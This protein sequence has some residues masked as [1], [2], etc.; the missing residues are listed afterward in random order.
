MI[1]VLVLLALLGVS[2]LAMAT[3]GQEVPVGAI[4]AL[5]AV[6]VVFFGAGVHVAAVLGLLGI[7]VGLVFSDR[8]WWDFAGQTLWGPSSNFVLVA[9]PLFL[10]MGEILLR[11]GLSDRLYRALNLWLNRLPGGLLHTNIASCAVFSAIS[12]SSV[13]T[14]ATMGSVA[15]PYFTG[16]AYSQRM[17]LGSLA[18]GGAL[19]NLIPP[20]ITFIVYGL[21]T[22]TSVGALYMA[23]LLPGVLV[24]G[25]FALVILAAR[26]GAADGAAGFGAARAQAA[27]AARPA[28]DAGADGAGARLHLCRL[29]DADRGGGARRGGRGAVRG[30]FGGKLSFRLLN[31]S[32][33]ATARNTALLG[34][35]ILGAYLLNYVLTTI[36]VPQALAALMAGLPL[37]PWAIMACILALYLALGTFMEGFSMIITTIPV[38][39]PIVTALGYDPVWFGVVVTMLVEIAQISPPDGTVMYV[40]QGMRPKPGGPITDVF[41]GVLPFLGGVSAGGGAADGVAGHR[42]LAAAGLGLVPRR[43]RR[44]EARAGRR[45]AGFARH[46]PRRPVGSSGHG[47]PVVLIGRGG[48]AIASAPRRDHRQDGE[49]AGGAEQVRRPPGHRA[50][51]AVPGAVLVVQEADR[52]AVVPRHRLP[53]DAGVELQHLR[54]FGEVVR[55]ERGARYARTR[56]FEAPMHHEGVPEQHIAL[57][58][59]RRAAF[60]ARIAHRLDDRRLVPLMV[61][62]EAELALVAQ[63]RKGAVAAGD[64]VETPGAVVDVLER[65]PA[66]DDAS[67]SLGAVLIIAVLVRPG[68]GGRLEEH[69]LDQLGPLRP[70]NRARGRGDGGKGQHVE[71]GALEASEAPA[72]Q[73]LHVEHGVGK[74]AI[75]IEDVDL[76]AHVLLPQDR[77]AGPADLRVEGVAHGVAQGGRHQAAQHDVAVTLVSG[78]DFRWLV[79]GRIACIL[80]GVLRDAHAEPGRCF[81][82]Q[83]TVHAPYAAA[84]T[85][86]AGLADPERLQRRQAIRD[87]ILWLPQCSMKRCLFLSSERRATTARHSDAPPARRDLT[88]LSCMTEPRPLRIAVDIGGTFTDLQVLDARDGSVRAWKTPTTPEDPSIGL[89][90][91]VKEAAARFGFRLAEVGLLMHGTTIAT[92]AVLERRLARGALLTTAGFE[93]VLEIT[94][95]VRRELYRLDPDPFPV[96]VPRDLRLGVQERMRADGTAELPLDEA[97]V[98][99]LVERLRDGAASR[100]SR[101]ACCTATPIRRMSGG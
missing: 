97:A 98:P 20:G 19:G 33:E 34:L 36:N 56:G 71:R 13:A 84:T 9:V 24:T 66:G 65:E 73:I 81:G 10:L 1:A 85:N 27:G 93:D 45:A 41:A 37:P 29:G 68:A 12:G 69:G 46:A 59:I 48:H 62:G 86:P 96:L 5:T 49:P 80:L 87:A 25:L 92:N 88:G 8:P 2:V 40:L 57:R 7:L 77:R 17:V 3:G 89:M 79:R 54:A 32:A 78:G 82:C 51:Q 43:L 6:F 28:A 75:R 83:Q 31:A 99:A 15:L 21:I 50:H 4:L 18:A 61:E 26:P 23:A 74:E 90:Q 100:R 67:D 52:H 22:E 76:V 95:H 101:S 70:E 14:A 64:H 44:G 94:R 55:G 39:F 11:A 47:L 16:S 91:G 72:F 42:A 63:Q 60:E 58:Q 38:V 30:L 53:S 35:I